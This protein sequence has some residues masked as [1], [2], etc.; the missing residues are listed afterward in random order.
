[1]NSKEAAK[2]MNL[3]VDT[4]RY[5]ERIGVMPPVERNENGYRNYRNVDLNWIFIIKRL[6]EAGLSIEALLEFATLTEK[7]GDMVAAKKDILTEQL[8]ELDEKMADLERTR[9]LLKYKLDTFD[10]HLGKFGVDGAGTE[11]A[12]KLWEDPRFNRKARTN[13]NK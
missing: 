11:S 8:G 7:S 10:H 9:N 3:P 1:M 5:Y 4:L 13:E 12:D 6:R 2:I